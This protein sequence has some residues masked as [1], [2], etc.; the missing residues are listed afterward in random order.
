[1]SSPAALEASSAPGLNFGQFVDALARCGLLGFSSKC[2]EATRTL[3]G[4]TRDKSQLL[5]TAERVQ[6]VFIT[7]MR[8]HD[9]QHVDTR[10][11]QVARLASTNHEEGGASEDGHKLKSKKQ[12]ETRG[13]TARGGH[14]AKKTGRHATRGINSG[15]PRGGGRKA[16]V[17]DPKTT[18]VLAPIQTT[19]RGGNQRLV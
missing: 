19:P 7:Q 11:Q 14:G 12:R 17:A 2:T 1:M 13:H 5:S 6:A 15:G 18:T 3:C 16:A 4:V 10:L 8:L 9:S